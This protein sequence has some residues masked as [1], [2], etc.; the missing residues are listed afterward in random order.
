MKTLIKREKSY[1][2][3]IHN[4]IEVA[5]ALTGVFKG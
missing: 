5:Q 3:I 2:G 4:L 1:A